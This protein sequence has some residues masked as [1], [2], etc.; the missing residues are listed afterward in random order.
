MTSTH[1]SGEGRE[2]VGFK[3]GAGVVN[4]REFPPRIVKTEGFERLF[5]HYTGLKGDE[6]LQYLQDFQTRALQVSLG[7][8]VLT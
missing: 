1:T 2:D 4:S 5:E 6:L 8:F 3:G 7:S